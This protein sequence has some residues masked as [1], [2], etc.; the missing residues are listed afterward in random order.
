MSKRES[1]AMGHDPLAWIA[2][3]DSNKEISRESEPL[4]HEDVPEAAT[5]LVIG[6]AEQAAEGTAILLEGDV[7]IANIQALHTQF[8]DA[9][10]RAAKVTIQAAELSHVDTS[11][12]QLLLAFMRD[13]KKMD[14]EVQWQGAPESLKKT[15]AVLGLSEKMKL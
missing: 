1:T 4:A 7:G 12:V 15:I 5:E 11:A 6:L 8:T 10:Q 3:G 13:A 2:T 9:L 14:V